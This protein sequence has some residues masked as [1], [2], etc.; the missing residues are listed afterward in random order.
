MNTERKSDTGKHPQE[1]AVARGKRRK[2]NEGLLRVLRCA[3]AAIGCT[4]L[5]LGLLLVI[6]PLFR[7]QKIYVEGNSYCSTEEIL[8]L[9]GIQVG[10]ELFAVDAG[11]AANAIHRQLDSYLETV[12]VAGRFPGTVVITVVEEKNLMFTEFDGAYYSFNTN[13]TVLDRAESADAF[14][15]LLFVK[16]PE[17]THMAVGNRILFANNL[18]DEEVMNTDYIATLVNSLDRNGLL[19]YVTSLDCARKYNVSFVLNDTLRLEVGKVSDMDAK[20]QLASRIMEE[21]QTNGAAYVTLD[22]SNLQKS[23]YRVLDA[24]EFMAIIRR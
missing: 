22:V 10:D 1:S 15:G 11:K 21:K 19:P 12:N 9:S 5:V 2:S 13:F 14:A 3:M 18:F 8:Q 7:V 20:L 24:E 16:L 23:T 17:V 6:L 4:V